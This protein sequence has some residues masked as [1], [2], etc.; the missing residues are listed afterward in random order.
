MKR[1]SPEEQKLYDGI[2][3]E[4]LHLLETTSM[5]KVYK[6][7]VLRAFYNEGDIRMALTEEDILAA[8]KDF[9]GAGTNWKDLKPDGNHQDYLQIT[10][11]EHLR[12]IMNNPVHFLLRSGQGFFVEKEGYAIALNDDLKEVIKSDAF[13]AQMGDIISYRTMDYYQRRYRETR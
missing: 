4:F 12:N 13:R 8:W 6:M 7:P 11:K 5:S 1:L 3:R 9:F 10:D 2:G